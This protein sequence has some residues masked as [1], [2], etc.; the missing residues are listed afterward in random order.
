MG[1]HH[2]PALFS[3]A[4]RKALAAAGN[5]AAC[6][7]LG[8]AYSCGS[9]GL[10][11]DLVAAHIWFNLAAM[12][13]DRRGLDQRSEIAHEMDARQIAEAQRQAR[14]LCAA[15]ATLQAA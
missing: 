1:Q 6:Y 3:L 15:R 2:Q 13:G 10:P 4:Q 11:V 8:M 9:D 7:D 14:A 5:A 12:A